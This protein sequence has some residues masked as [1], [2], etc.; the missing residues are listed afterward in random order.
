MVLILYKIMFRPYADGKQNVSDVAI[1]IFFC[2]IFRVLSV[3]YI[4]RD[5]G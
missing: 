3:G 1:H 5:T 2:Q 4:V